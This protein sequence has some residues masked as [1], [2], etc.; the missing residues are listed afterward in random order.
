MHFTYKQLKTLLALSRYG[1][2]TA[3]AEQLHVTQ[4]TVSIQL[5]ELTEQ[6]GLPLYEVISKKV[7]LTEMG[8]K[9]AATALQM[10]SAW[11]AFEQAVAETKGLQK[12]RLKVSV[13][14]TAKYFMPRLLG[15]FCKKFPEVDLQLEV[16]NRDGVVKRLENNEDDLY[17][18]S[19]PPE[20]LTLVDHVIRDNPL[21][22]IAPTG[23]PLEGR[24]N[25]DPTQLRDERFI[26]RE[27]GSG[28][29]MAVD[30]H[31]KLHKLNWR[32]K[33]VLGNNEAIRESVSAGLGLAV[34]SS[35]ALPKSPEQA[36]LCLLDVEH[37]PIESRWHAVYP[38]GRQLTPLTQTFLNDL[39]SSG[40]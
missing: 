37:F 5:K 32:V 40:F 1:S 17:I 4:P 23:H 2:L 34:L 39:L 21:Y 30:E 8:E 22:V 25:I 14:S 15:N 18:M 29:R 19:R 20:H 35:F 16:L 26:F 9:L 3:A 31:I 12:G 28:T 10:E 11:E 6:V 27:V 38:K 7:Y 33:L 36:G 24:A 13:V